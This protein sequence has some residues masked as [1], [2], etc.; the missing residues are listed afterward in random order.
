VRENLTA[1]ILATYSFFAFMP[2]GYMPGSGGAGLLQFCTSS[3]LVTRTLAGEGGSGTHISDAGCPFALLP[4][5]AT[6]PANP[7]A[8]LV[9]TAVLELRQ[10]PRSLS[11]GGTGPVRVQSAR[12]PPVNS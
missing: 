7:A 4:A 9:A 6:P 3:G 1:L 8:V 5:S 2:T 11:S 10:Y 12:A